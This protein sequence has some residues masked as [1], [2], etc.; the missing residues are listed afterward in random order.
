MFK[1][2]IGYYCPE[3]NKIHPSCWKLDNELICSTCFSED[4][5]KIIT[6]DNFRTNLKHMPLI[7]NA[8]EH[9]KKIA[10]KD[11]LNIHNPQFSKIEKEKMISILNAG[12]RE[13][14]LKQISKNIKNDL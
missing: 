12:L 3:C 14:K 8:L 1:V 2:E 9:F 13:E 11:S 10:E 7:S 5:I 6:I 4:E